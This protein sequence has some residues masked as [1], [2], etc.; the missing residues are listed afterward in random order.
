MTEIARARKQ[1]G[2]RRH[3]VEAMRSARI[4]QM[5]GSR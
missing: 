2:A 1:H 5:R 4:E 3:L